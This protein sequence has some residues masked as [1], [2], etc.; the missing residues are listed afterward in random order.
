MIFERI[1]S[2]SATMVLFYLLVSSPANAQR[3]PREDVID[4]PATGEGLRT[5]NVFQSNMVLQ[6]DQPIRVWGWASPGET[7][8]VNFLDHGVAAVAGSDRRWEVELPAVASSVKPTSMIVCGEEES[9][10]LENILVGD[11]WILGGQSNME[12][13]I[14]K[15]ENGNLEII[16]ANFPEI[17]VLTVPYGQGPDAKQNFARLHEW[18][19]WFGRHFRKGDW[20][21]CNPKTVR[22]LSAIGYVFARRIHKAAQ[23]PIGVIDASRGGTTIETWTPMEVLRQMDGAATKAK[24]ETVD[25]AVAEWDANEDLKRRIEQHKAWTD[26]QIEQGKQIPE[27]RKRPPSDLRPGP[28]GDHNYPGHCYAGMI[29]PLE[30]LAVKGVIFHQGYNNAFDGSL[31]VEMYREV[32]R[33]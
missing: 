5:S 13:E 17:R 22:E 11:V 23:V 12:F 33:R 10:E 3:M 24:L 1:A 8:S 31:G 16:S 28:I 15:V 25:T 19:D 7:V 20:E 27:D 4:V 2:F 14:A 32:C 9:I 18:S 6:R 29:A 21:E 30:G 26:R